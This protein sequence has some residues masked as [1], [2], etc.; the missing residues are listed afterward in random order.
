MNCVRNES[1]FTNMRFIS[2]W[3]KRHIWIFRTKE[4]AGEKLQTVTLCKNLNSTCISSVRRVHITIQ[5]YRRF[6]HLWSMFE[7]GTKA[8]FFGFLFASFFLNE[9]V[10]RRCRKAFQKFFSHFIYSPFGLQIAWNC[11]KWNLFASAIFCKKAFPI[12]KNGFK[13]FAVHRNN[14]NDRR[15][16]DELWL[17]SV[18]LKKKNT[19]FLALDTYFLV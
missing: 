6:V 16:N 5:N 12:W 8:I 9:Y 14:L 3:L 7:K 4:H 11:R 17:S 1:I 18:Y 19:L 2:H 10:E 13:L 15:K